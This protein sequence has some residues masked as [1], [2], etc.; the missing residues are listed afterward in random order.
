MLRADYLL[1]MDGDLSLV[2]D[3]AVAVA[4]SDIAAAGSADE[5]L[6]KYSSENVRFC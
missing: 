2:T 4:G 5:I 6:N 1:T 3:G